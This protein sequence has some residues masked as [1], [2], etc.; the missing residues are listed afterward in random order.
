MKP[1]L[2]FTLDE[3]KTLSINLRILLY[4]ILICL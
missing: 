4:E 2:K 3:D 1:I